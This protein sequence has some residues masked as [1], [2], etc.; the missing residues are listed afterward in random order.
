MAMDDAAMAQILWDTLGSTKDINGN[1]VPPTDIMKAYTKGVVEMMK[2]CKFSHD[3]TLVTMVVGAGTVTGSISPGGTV[4]DMDENKLGDELKAA[5]PLA[6]AKVIDDSSLATKDYL[7]E[8]LQIAFALLTGT[9]TSLPP[10]PNPNPGSITAGASG[11]IIS[12]I[13]GADLYKKVQEATVDSIN[14]D[15]WLGLSGTKG[16]VFFTDLC[17]YLITNTTATYDNGS[18]GGTAI[19]PSVTPVPPSSVTATDGYFT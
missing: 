10:S 18:I 14:L 19:L 4:S 12:G 11:G 13:V 3:W 9:H 7:T 8:K 17:N 15:E 5:I 1:T 6:P 16:E 2:S